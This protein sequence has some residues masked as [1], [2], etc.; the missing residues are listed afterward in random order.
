MDTDFEQEKQRE[1]KLIETN[2]PEPHVPGPS[3]ERVSQRSHEGVLQKERAG[4]AIRQR[5]AAT[6][7]FFCVQEVLTCGY[8][9]RDANGPYLQ[10]PGRTLLAAVCAG[11]GAVLQNAEGGK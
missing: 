2:S 3:R 4:S 5:Q 1:E 9:W 8:F 10:S 11:C 7:I 6:K